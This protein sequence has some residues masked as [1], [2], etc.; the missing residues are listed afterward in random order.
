MLGLFIL[1]D[2]DWGI[3][4]SPRIILLFKQSL[5]LI[6]TIDQR[7]NYSSDSG[8]RLDSKVMIFTTFNNIK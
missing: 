4:Y 3:L 5:M 6:V 2:S 7:G 1:Q 8:L